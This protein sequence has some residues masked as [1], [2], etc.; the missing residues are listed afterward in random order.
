PD[1]ELRGRCLPVPG[2]AM[3]PH[4]C[5]NGWVREEVQA[6]E[7]LIERSAMNALA[8]AARRAAIRAAIGIQHSTGRCWSVGVPNIGFARPSLP[9]E[10]TMQRDIVIS[11]PVRSPIGSF[12]GSLKNTPASALG[13]HV[14]AT[15]VRRAGLDPDAVDGVILG[16]VVQAG[17]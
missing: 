1:Y 6:M 9:L 3:A 15:A 5:R 13:A 17:N 12:G 16:N 2:A 10:A 7:G 11:A 8:R 14:V 4:Q